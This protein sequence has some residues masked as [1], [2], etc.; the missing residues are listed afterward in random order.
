[1]TDTLQYGLHLGNMLGFCVDEYTGKSRLHFAE[2]IDGALSVRVL[3]TAVGVPS[4][5][6]IDQIFHADLIAQIKVGVLGSELL[7]GGNVDEAVLNQ[8][9]DVSLQ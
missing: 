9:Q 1:L 5:T 2:H 6:C 3:A 4:E 8:R 7:G